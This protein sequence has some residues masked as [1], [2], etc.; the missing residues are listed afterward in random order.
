MKNVYNLSFLFKGNRKYVQ[1]PDIFD[2]VIEII[3]NNFD[4]TKITSVKYAAHNML[5]QNADLVITD[6]FD[7]K[8]YSFFN[9]IITFNHSNRKY[10]AIVIQNNKLID[11][12]VEYSEDIVRNLSE[13][14]DD[15][16]VFKNELNDSLTE[17]IVSMNKYYL[18]QNVIEDGKWIVT[19]FDYINLISTEDIKNNVISLQLKNNFNNLLTKSLVRVDG[20]IVGN[21]YFSLV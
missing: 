3:C 17:I 18:Q 16:I 8:E 13:I 11:S 20:E 21:L 15:M 12:A 19:K 7:P 14:S 6:E 10:Y 9:S 4:K 2:A 5:H 1:G